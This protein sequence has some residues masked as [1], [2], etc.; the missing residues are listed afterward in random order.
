MKCGYHWFIFVSFSYALFS[1]LSSSV[2]YE[3]FGC[4]ALCVSSIDDV[5]DWLLNAVGS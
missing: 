3:H 1:W 4:M 2:F 5:K